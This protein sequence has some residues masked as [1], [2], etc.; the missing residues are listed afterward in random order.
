MTREEFDGLIGSELW[1]FWITPKR[2]I[3]ASRRWNS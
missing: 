2:D 3:E 1:D